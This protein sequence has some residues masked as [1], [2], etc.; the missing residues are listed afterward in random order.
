MERLYPIIR[1]K[2]RPL[3]DADASV[4][5]VANAS[6]QASATPEPA[7]PGSADAS[8]AAGLVALPE[9]GGNIGLPESPSPVPDVSAPI[10]SVAAKENENERNNGSA[11]ANAER[12]VRGQTA[13]RNQT[14]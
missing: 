6:P 10:I 9:K 14:E 13:T 2:R 1:R 11:T 12:R 5:P 7:P 8:N 3:I 4:V